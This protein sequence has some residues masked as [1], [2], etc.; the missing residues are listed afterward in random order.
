[1]IKRVLHSAQDIF[2]RGMAVLVMGLLLT[3]F[4]TVHPSHQANATSAIPKDPVTLVI[5]KFEQPHH[6]GEPATGLPLQNADLAAMKPVSDVKFAVTKVPNL[7]VTTDQGRRIA[8]ELSLHD[9]LDRVDGREPTRT[10]ITNAQGKLTMGLLDPGLYVVEET[11]TPAGVVPTD[12]FLVLLPMRHPTNSGWLET[13]HVYPKN[14][15]VD[16]SLSVVD[17]NAVQ[18]GDDI[19]WQISASI[20]QQTSLDRYQLLNLLGAGVKLSQRLADMNVSVSTGARLVPDTDYTVRSRNVDGQEGFEIT[21]TATGRAKLVQAR[22]TSPSAH[23][24]VTYNAPV[25]SSGEHTNEVQL[26]VNNAQI[27]S[28][29]ATT[30]F[31]DL[32]V[33]VHE[34]NNPQNLIAGVVFQLYGSADDALRGHNPLTINGADQWTTKADGSLRINGLRLSGFVNG[35]VRD[36]SDP[37][38]DFYYIQP[39]SFP[40]PWV[41]ATDPTEVELTS[42]LEVYELTLEAEHPLDTSPPDIDDDHPKEPDSD[43][44]Q[45]AGIIPG[46]NSQDTTGLASTGARIVGLILAALAFLAAG[47]YA[48]RRRHTVNGGA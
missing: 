12:P 11:R 2:A 26:T 18:I 48:V 41:G 32:Q 7:D 20:P 43:D 1:M 8:E 37:L 29:T 17:E 15:P 10:G 44:D 24:Q 39:Q 46:D 47:I 38:F 16:V 31:G 35:L 36:S 33:L 3:G 23:L 6:P 14:A 19:T 34:R 22:Q 13:V 28:D 21:F 42:A 27:V 40:T 4:L 45:H 9:A 5:Q 30:K 25:T